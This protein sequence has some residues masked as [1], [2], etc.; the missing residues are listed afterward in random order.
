MPGVPFSGPV[1]RGFEISVMP[2]QS[3]VLHLGCYRLAYHPPYLSYL[4][5]RPSAYPICR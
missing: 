3:P 1:A 5:I 4:L 2:L